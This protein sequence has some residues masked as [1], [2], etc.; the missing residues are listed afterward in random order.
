MAGAAVAGK[1]ALPDDLSQAER[2][3]RSQMKLD[4]YPAVRYLDTHGKPL[5]FPQF[6]AKAAG[7]LRYTVSRNATIRVATVSLKRPL[8]PGESVVI[9]P[10]PYQDADV[11]EF[12]GRT[13][14]GRQVDNA[15]FAGKWTVI[16]FYF[17]EC[18][19]CIA[20]VPALNDFQRDNPDVQVLSVTFQSDAEARA[21]VAKR[22]LKW[23]VL[24]GQQKLID[25][26]GVMGYPNITLIS[27]QGTVVSQWYAH[28]RKLSVV[29][30]QQ[31]LARQFGGRASIKPSPISGAG[32]AEWVTM[33]REGRAADISATA[34]L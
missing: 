20:E 16:S 4:A 22:G 3:F 27:P 34:S 33:A 7:G 9:K 24:A 10:G 23:P 31:Q 11:P 17:A 18:G 29:R 6:L 21:F 13:I 12:S 32:M 25:A 19:P 30:A 5:E 15:M 2:E 8:G 1:P 28:N 14:D 26:M